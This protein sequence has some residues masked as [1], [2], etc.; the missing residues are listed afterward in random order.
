MKINLGLKQKISSFLVKM[1]TRK[2]MVIENTTLYDHYFDLTI[3]LPSKKEWIPGDKVQF[4][5]SSKELRSY[6]PYEFLEDGRTFKTLIY[7]NKHGE[8]ARFL[9]ELNPMD[10]FQILGP[11]RSLNSTEMKND[12]VFFADESSLGLAFSL[13]HKIKEFVFECHHLESFKKLVENKYKL[14][15]CHYFERKENLAHIDQITAQLIKEYYPEIY[16]TGQKESSLKI[17]QQLI[18]AGI[19]NEKIKKKLYWG[20]MTRRSSKKNAANS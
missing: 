9:K 13:R 11:R 12:V 6:T 10:R 16:L 14:T 19:P 17:Y 2:A 20:F 4:L 5:I 8:G 15:N 18:H 7:D 1:L 3:K